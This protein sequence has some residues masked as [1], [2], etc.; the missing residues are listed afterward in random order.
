MQVVFAILCM[1]MYHPPSKRRQLIQRIVIYSLMTLA[2][3]IL[4]V[5]LV[6]VMLGYQFNQNDGKL[7]QG[8]LLQF[9]SRPSGASVT[10]D[11]TS[12]GSRTASKATV[13]SGQHFVTMSQSGYSSWQKSVNVLPGSVV[14]LNYARL[15]PNDLPVANVADFPV[16]SSTSPSPDD[17]WMTIKEDPAT[18]NIRL[19]DVS[20]DTVKV[21]ELA[22]PA[23]SYTHPSEGKTQSFTLD[24]WDND[25]RFVLVKHMYDDGKLEWLVVDTQNVAATKN[26]TKVLDIDASKVVFSPSSSSI[27]YAQIGSDVRK[28]DIGASTLSRPLVTNVAE[29]S[30]YDRSTIL[31]SSV[32]NPETKT[33]DVGYYQDGAEAPEVI[34]SFADDGTPPLHIV[35]GKYFG[36]TYTAVNHGDITEVLKGDLPHPDTAAQDKPQKIASFSV[37]GGAQYL[38]IVADGRFVVAQNEGTYMVYDIELA[39]TTTTPLKGSSPI[40]QKLVWLDNYHVWSDRD[41]MLRLYEF[42]GANQH[43]IMPVTAGFSAVLSPNSKYIYGIIHAGNG[44]WHLE[45]VRMIV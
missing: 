10:V 19:A 39:K 32:I 40:T 18:P 29:F 25:S 1:A 8:G 16:V 31:F 37:P 17:K 5:I 44:T 35:V 33:R 34:Q 26:I 28:I 20:G 36:D 41:N 11:G 22:L 12:V 4:V 14:W 42:D 27:L 9:D 21:K 38:S 2:V 23:D 43:D 3:C 24:T 13:T 6:F 45:R 30:L 7:E 15:V